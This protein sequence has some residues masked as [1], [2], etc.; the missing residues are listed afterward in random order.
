MAWSTVNF[1]KYRGKGKTLPQIIF[2]D[3]DWFFWAIE[4]NAFRGRGSLEEEASRIDSRARAI[5]IPKYICISP[6]YSGEK[7]VA[8]YIIHRPTGKFANVEIVPA[9]RPEHEGSSPTFRKSVI[10][11]SVARQIAQYD[12]RGCKTLISSAKKVLFGNRFARMTKDRCEDFF[13][14]P[15]NFDL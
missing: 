9:N 5:R 12:K 2:D 8:E 15:A 11:L 6:D 3:P 1:G 7:L 10:D 13:D 4:N 14:D